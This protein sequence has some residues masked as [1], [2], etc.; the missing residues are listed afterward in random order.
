MKMTHDSFTHSLFLSLIQLLSI[1]SH[2]TL[3]L[4]LPLSVSDGCLLSDHWELASAAAITSITSLNKDDCFFLDDE[5]SSQLECISH[6]AVNLPL[7]KL[8]NEILC[9]SEENQKLVDV[10]GTEVTANY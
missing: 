8:M 4:S 3:F 5:Q 6:F 10:Q 2:S 9:S 1:I 7:L